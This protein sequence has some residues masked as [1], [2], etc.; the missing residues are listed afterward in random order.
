[1]GQLQEQTAVRVHSWTG[2]TSFYIA[3]DWFNDGA[4]HAVD[5]IISN[6]GFY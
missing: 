6:F 5:V 3:F 1:L 4:T 2:I